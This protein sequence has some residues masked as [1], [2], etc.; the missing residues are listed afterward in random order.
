MARLLVDRALAIVRCE[1]LAQA[2]IRAG[3]R[4]ARLAIDLITSRLE[5][6]ATGILMARHQVTREEAVRL[7]RQASRTSQR[8][9]QEIAASVV[10]AGDL[11]S[12]SHSHAG[13]PARPGCLRVA[14]AR[15]FGVGNG[16]GKSS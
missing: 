1:R 8:E 4:A 12:L 11:A 6:E 14:A 9:L 15:R 2:E 5:G 16:S 3:N 7:L 13:R 10:C